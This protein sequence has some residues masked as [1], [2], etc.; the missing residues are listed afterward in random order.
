MSSI[1]LR[2]HYQI[3]AGQPSANGRR[4]TS[5]IENAS[6]IETAASACYERKYVVSGDPRTT[7]RGRKLLVIEALAIPRGQP[8]RG[9][10][11]NGLQ[12]APVIANRQT[13]Q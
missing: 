3:V 5:G 10:L 6:E 8:I 1:S 2:V 4:R 7:R 12:T 9:R 11:R 13:P